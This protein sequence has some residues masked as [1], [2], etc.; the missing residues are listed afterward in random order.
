MNQ[1]T[2]TSVINAGAC[3]VKP[4]TLGAPLPM[5]TTFSSASAR[6]WR[7]LVHPLDLLSPIKSRIL[8]PVDGYRDVKVESMGLL[9]DLDVQ[10][11]HPSVLVV[12]PH[13]QRP[14]LPGSAPAF[15]KAHR[16]YATR[17]WRVRDG[18]SRTASCTATRMREVPAEANKFMCQAEVTSY[19]Q[20]HSVEQKLEVAASDF[21][22]GG[23]HLAQIRRDILVQ[24]QIGGGEQRAGGCLL[25][26]LAHV[27]TLS[28]RK[29]L[30]FDAKGHSGDDHDLMF[31]TITRR[32]ARVGSARL[33]AHT[34]RTP[35]SIETGPNSTRSHRPP[36][37]PGRAGRR[38]GAVR[39]RHCGPM[40][41]T[42]A[43]EVVRAR[44]VSNPCA[45]ES[46]SDTARRGRIVL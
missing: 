36:T 33:H 38:I 11:D 5:L 10:V 32:S 23:I 29:R 22:A 43:P 6:R 21:R 19:D 15:S 16:T 14:F 37:L 30:G 2:T 41:C 17:I 24:D 34:A 39:R 44:A 27:F 40:A 3:W 31:R 13:S 9:D 25:H 28:H 12:I 18:R 45:A 26:E 7:P 20:Y 1:A 4:G 8:V 35:L 42:R 46:T